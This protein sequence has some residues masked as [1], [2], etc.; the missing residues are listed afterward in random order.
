M[1]RSEVLDYNHV[2]PTPSLLRVLLQEWKFSVTLKWKGHDP[3]ILNQVSFLK[4]NMLILSPRWKLIFSV[5]QLELSQTLLTDRPWLPATFIWNWIKF[6]IKANV[7]FSLFFP[8]SKKYKK[9]YLKK[10]YNKIC[11]LNLFHLAALTFQK[12][13]QDCKGCQTRCNKLSAK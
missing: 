12:Q 1:K 6:Y 2:S 13:I 10:Y 11:L 8:S 9:K 4:K 3:R 7:A 5:I